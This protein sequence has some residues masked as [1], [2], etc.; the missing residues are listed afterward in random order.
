MG[1]MNPV[2]SVGSMKFAKIGYVVISAALCALGTVLIVFPGFSI[3]ALGRVCGIILISFGIVKLVGFFCKDLFRLAFQ[4]DLPFGIL[5]CAVGILVL[6]QPES[7]MTVICVAL[8]ISTLLDGIFKIMIALD[9][10]KFGIDKWWLIFVLAVI[11][12]ILGLVLMF[13]PGEGSEILAVLLGITLLTEGI[14]NFTTAITAVKII[15]YQKPDVIEDDF[16]QREE[17]F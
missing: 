2:R 4:Y 3:I 16:I 13:R 8:G 15:R 5:M 10:K 12:G 1:S 14:L 7:L 9:S 11:S 6:V 17:T